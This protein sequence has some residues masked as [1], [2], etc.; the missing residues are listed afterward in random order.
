MLQ[1]K[2]CKMAKTKKNVMEALRAALKPRMSAMVA[3]AQGVPASLLKGDREAIIAEVLHRHPGEACTH[4]A[5]E[6]A[7]RKLRH[8]ETGTSMATRSGPPPLLRGRPQKRA[9]PIAPQPNTRA[10]KAALERVRGRRGDDTAQDLARFREATEGAR[11]VTEDMAFL[12]EGQAAVKAA[13][14]ASKK[15][16]EDQNVD[17]MTRVLARCE[18]E[19]LAGLAPYMDGANEF[20]VT[21]A[22]EVGEEETLCAA[23]A[24]AEA[25]PAEAA[26]AEEEEVTSPKMKAC[27]VKSAKKKIKRLSRSACKLVAKLRD[28]VLELNTAEVEEGKLPTHPALSVSYHPGDGTVNTWVS[29]EDV[30]GSARNT[31]ANLS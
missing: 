21:R 10:D 26:P 18:A 22:Q 5:V 4:H 28:A 20:L 2:R 27:K 23:P 25:A 12:P 11:D 6:V 9:R 15:I 8:A 31:V 19:R 1:E 3:A 13:F 16:A 30:L 24:P 17:V 7:W 14:T 29:N